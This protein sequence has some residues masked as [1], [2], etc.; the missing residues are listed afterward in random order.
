M[1]YRSNCLVFYFIF[2][3]FISFYLSYKVRANYKQTATL[4]FTAACNN[5]ELAIEVAVA[6]FDIHSRQAFAAVIGSLVELLVLIS[7][8]NLALC[9]EK[10][11]FQL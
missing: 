11:F 8:L 7:L 5:F 9:F 1:L 6:V 2:M 10:R 4:S 3:F